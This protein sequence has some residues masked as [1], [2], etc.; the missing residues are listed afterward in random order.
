MV[1]GYRCGSVTKSC[2]VEGK[3]VLKEQLENLKSIAG[4]VDGNKVW[5]WL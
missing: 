1:V 3:G 4:G 2:S 5:L